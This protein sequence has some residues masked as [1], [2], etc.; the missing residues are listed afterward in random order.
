METIP[1]KIEMNTASLRGVDHSL[2]EVEDQGWGKE[3]SKIVFKKEN[4]TFYATKAPSGVRVPC[5]DYA[6]DKMAKILTDLT[7][8]DDIHDVL[9]TTSCCCKAKYKKPA[10]IDEIRKI[11]KAPDLEIASS[12]KEVFNDQGIM[13]LEQRRKQ[14]DSDAVM[15]MF[16]EKLNAAQKIDDSIKNDPMKAKTLILIH[17]VHKHKDD[18]YTTK[19]REMMTDQALRRIANGGGDYAAVTIHE[20]DKILAARKD[21]V[22]IETFAHG[23]SGPG[24]SD[25]VQQKGVQ[26]SLGGGM[27]GAQFAI[28]TGLDKVEQGKIKDVNLIVCHSAYGFAADFQSA[29]KTDEDG[30]APV[31]HAPYGSCKVSNDVFDKGE[32]TVTPIDDDSIS[33]L[34]DAEH[35]DRFMQFDN[36][37]MSDPDKPK[38]ELFSN[39]SG[40]YENVQHKQVFVV[41]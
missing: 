41:D 13:R 10:T 12:M 25:F 31:V 17:D 39:N 28:D 2:Q 32:L 15:S 5:F 27:T 40:S 26:L 34:D 14:Y 30:N 22:N 16:K 19:N 8:N 9:N 11:V 29:L 38:P 7:G 35:S 4:D 3:D 24:T 23:F 6:N 1:S 18:D 33:I 20:L 37:V 21:K 36:G